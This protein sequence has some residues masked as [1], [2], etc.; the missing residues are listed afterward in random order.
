MEAIST[1]NIP[2]RVAYPR[3]AAI[4]VHQ[5]GIRLFA[6]RTL[7]R[8]YPRPHPTVDRRDQ[9]RA[10][11]AKRRDTEAEAKGLARA[12]LPPTSGNRRLELWARGRDK[13]GW[14]SE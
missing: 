10:S 7:D 11:H 2:E 1:S 5:I 13:T 12:G 8:S 3:P 4:P 9:S 6:V 14:G